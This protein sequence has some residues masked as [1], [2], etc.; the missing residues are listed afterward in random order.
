MRLSLSAVL[1]GLF[2]F[3][4]SEE[5]KYTPAVASG[6]IVAD[7]DR[8]VEKVMKIYSSIE[9][10]FAEANEDLLSSDVPVPE[11]LNRL[12]RLVSDKRAQSVLQK[13]SC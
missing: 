12:A 7:V 3:A 11:V 8:I 2:A 10:G 5:E 9:G 6:D 4:C 13:T 1:V